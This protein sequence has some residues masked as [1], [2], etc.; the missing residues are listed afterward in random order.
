MDCHAD[1]KKKSNMKS[2]AKCKVERLTKNPD[3]RPPCLRQTVRW[4]FTVK[5]LIRTDLAAWSASA[6]SPSYLVTKHQRYPETWEPSCALNCW[7]FI[8]YEYNSVWMNVFVEMLITSLRTGGLNLL[9]HKSSW[10]QRKVG[11][12]VSL[13]ILCPDQTST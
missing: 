12:L 2:M 7:Y 9:A 3:F 10:L 8:W 13:F 4:V 1:K 6:H 5:M 11:D